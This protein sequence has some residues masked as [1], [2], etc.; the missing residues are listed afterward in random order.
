MNAYTI[1]FDVI[2]KINDEQFFKL[3]R[4]N[5]ELKLEQN[6]N[7]EIIIMSP[8][9]GETGKRNANLIT[10][11]GIWNRQKKLGQIFDS[12]TGF[13]LPLGSN[14]SPDVAYIQQERWDKLTQ[15]EKEKFPPIAPDFVLELKSKTDSLKEL[16]EKMQEYMNNGVKLGWLINP[17]KKQVEI[18]RQGQEKVILDNP[19]TLS[20]E[21]ILPEFRLDLALIW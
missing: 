10:D 17:E 19:Q 18:Y 16:Q 6:Q 5:P 13:K 15:E 14:R 3:C 1:N 8:T 9:G 21:D 4:N 7:G 11:F 20:G 12:S 2:T